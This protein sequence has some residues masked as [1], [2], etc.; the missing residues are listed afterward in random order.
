MRRKIF[1]SYSHQDE[2]YARAIHH[3]ISAYDVA[4]DLMFLDREKE[5]IAP[6]DEWLERIEDEIFET[7]VALFLVSA[8]F[9]TSKF[10]MET[11]MP[12][13]LKAREGDRRLQVRWVK[14]TEVEAPSELQDFQGFC[15]NAPLTGLKDESNRQKAIDRIAKSLV[16]ELNVDT[17]LRDQMYHQLKTI[18]RREFGLRLGRPKAIGMNSVAFAGDGAGFRAMIKAR[19]ARSIDRNIAVTNDQLQKE[20]SEVKKLNHAALIRFAGGLIKD[21]LQLLVSDYLPR[22][23]SLR[24]HMCNARNKRLGID[25][26]RLTIST[27]AEVLQLYHEAGLVYGNIRPKDLMIEIPRKKKKTPREE[28]EIP[29]EDEWRIRVQSYRMSQIDAL[30]EEQET[31]FLFHPARTIRR[32]TAL[33]SVITSTSRTWLQAISLP[34]GTWRQAVTVR[35]SIW[36]ITHPLNVWACR[37]S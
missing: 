25:R 21:D 15:E 31:A 36:V 18:T 33:A 27:V 23:R 11:E 3:Q 17:T 1:I 8:H 6:G 7:R 10:I 34:I 4:D 14:L 37:D 20:L 35:R 13:I 24:E 9:K 12:S 16:K 28:E 22:A 26:V 30:S 19:Y 5:G 32:R 2:E 29:R